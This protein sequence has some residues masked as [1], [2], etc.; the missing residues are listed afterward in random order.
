MT[1]RSRVFHLRHHKRNRHFSDIFVHACCSCPSTQALQESWWDMMIEH[2]NLDLY[3][4]ISC[5]L[6]TTQ[7]P[8]VL[9]GMSVISFAIKKDFF[10]SLEDF[11][12]FHTL[13]SSTDL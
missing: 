13:A 3:V 1:T 5:L 7:M 2:F 10:M 8:S 12:Y 11:E 9:F 4:E 6:H